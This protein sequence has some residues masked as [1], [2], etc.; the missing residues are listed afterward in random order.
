M[1]YGVKSAI[2]LAHRNGFGVY[3]TIYY[4]HKKDVGYNFFC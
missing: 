2:Q 3:N 4:L 1:G